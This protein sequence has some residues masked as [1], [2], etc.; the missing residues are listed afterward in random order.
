M[1]EDKITLDD[2]YSV[3]KVLTYSLGNLGDIISS[4]FFQFLIFIFYYVVVGLN[5]LYLGVGFIIWSIWNAIN[6]PLLGALSDRTQTKWGKRKPWIILGIIPTAILLVVVW[7]PPLGS[8][9]AILIHFLV[10]VML[11]DLF[12][13]MYSLNQVSLF[14]EMFQ[15]LEQRAKS[16]T[17]IQFI[18]VFGLIIAILLPSLF[19]PVYR[20]PN[21]FM[22]Y[23]YAGLF[24]A[25]LFVIIAGLFVK[26]GIKER[27]EFSKDS[28]SS[29]SFFASLKFSMKNK[30][31]RKYVVANFAVF[32]VFGMLPVI[33]PLY[34]SF[35]LE[36]DSSLMQSLLLGVAILSA[37]FFM[38]FWRFISMKY[39]VKVGHISAMLS[40]ILTLLPFMFIT[41]II[42]AFIAYALV[43]MGLAGA[44]FFRAVTISSIIDEDELVTGV[45]REGGY[46]GINALII[47]LST[48]AIIVS[49]GFV[50]GSME[51]AVFDPSQ[52]TGLNLLALRSLIFIY[53]TIALCIG[54]LSMSRFPINKARYEEI[55][56]ELI[57]I[58]KKKKE[59]VKT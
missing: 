2:D 10:S 7:M 22:N 29:P 48:I 8:Q 30:S 38:L 36:I 41:E 44:L 20:D 56:K 16:N 27:K 52:M 28:E 24:M 59:Q 45:R 49:I 21:N 19:I 15:D 53:P 46:Y 17:I 11:F 12:F 6:D 33:S 42:G 58:H 14:P 32:Y 3:K 18:G 50:F 35:V 25:I 4:Q 13:T 57:E 39:G 5:L 1:A 43:G 51:L 9:E 23:R 54:I 55:R 26:F 47:R 31:F 40:F 34:L 37:G